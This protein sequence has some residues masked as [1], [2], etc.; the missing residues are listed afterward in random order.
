[1]FEQI[2]A[3]LLGLTVAAAG[4]VGIAVAT[5]TPSGAAPEFSVGAARMEWAQQQAAERRASSEEVEVFVELDDEVGVA[6]VGTDRALEALEAAMGVAA[7]QAQDALQHA[8]ERVAAGGS[9]SE[10]P[11]AEAGDATDAAPISVPAG[12]PSELPGGAPEGVP[13][14]NSDRP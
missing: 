12:P 2:I 1:M 5:G 3:W 14:G 8:A 11:G 9:D 10:D 6:N 4:A 7:P 13:S